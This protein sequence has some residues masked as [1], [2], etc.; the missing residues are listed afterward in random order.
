MPI[1]SVVSGHAKK[2]NRVT[3]RHNLVSF[4]RYI[5]ALTVIA[6]CANNTYSQTKFQLTKL[7]TNKLPKGIK[8]EGKVKNA[9][10]WKDKLGDNIVIT[11]ETGEYLNKKIKHETDGLDAELFAYHYIVLRDSI[12]QTWRVYDYIIDC[13]VDIE[14]SFVKNT[15]Q[16]TDLNSDGIAEIWLM[17]KT[18]CHGDVSP[19]DMKIIMFQGQQKFAIRGQEKVI[20]GIDEKGKKSYMGGEYKVDQTFK[21]GPKEFLE[22]AKKL[23]TKNIIETL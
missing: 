22:F 23:W 11:T 18:V 7:D 4:K 17:Y 6:L 10:R 8:F 5:F 13:P 20:I 19:C 9:V 21:T 12:K 2:E 3:M 14:A 15:F 16:I 1:A